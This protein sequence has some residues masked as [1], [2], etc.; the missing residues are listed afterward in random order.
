MASLLSAIQRIFDMSGGK[1]PTSHEIIT[2]ANG[3]CILNAYPGPYFHYV[4]DV[5][6]T[7]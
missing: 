4:L 1:L 7:F 6:K 2:K 5:L 3:I